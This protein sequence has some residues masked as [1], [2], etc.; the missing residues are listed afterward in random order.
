MDDAGEAHPGHVAGGGGL[1]GEVP[2][3]LVGVGELVGEEGAA[4]LLGED[5][6]VAPALAGQGALFL[7]DGSDVDDVHDQQVARLR[8]LDGERARERVDAARTP[9]EVPDWLAQLSRSPV[10]SLAL[11]VGG[12]SHRIS[13][14]RDAVV[15]ALN[16]LLTRITQALRTAASGTLR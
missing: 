12:R 8:A 9:D 1:A 6:G 11:T 16:P 14:A 2:D 4:V 13:L 15:V 10:A 3:G 5:A 7:R